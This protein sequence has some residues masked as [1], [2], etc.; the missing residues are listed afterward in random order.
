MNFVCT[1]GQLHHR[2]TLFKPC[3]CMRNVTYLQLSSVMWEGCLWLLWFTKYD[4]KHDGHSLECYVVL[5]IGGYNY[6]N[7]SRTWTL[8]T[9]CTLGIQ[10]SNDIPTDIEVIISYIMTLCKWLS[11]SE[12]PSSVYSCY[13]CRSRF[14]SSF[15]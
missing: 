14:H 6:V 13:E 4:K 11:I 5:F 3:D 12:C 7:T 1:Y 8:L 15:L 9:A 2:Q 10:I